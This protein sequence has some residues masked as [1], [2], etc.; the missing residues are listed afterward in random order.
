MLKCKI[1]GKEIDKRDNGR[2]RIAKYC[3]EECRKE[4]LRRYRI[5]WRKDKRENDKEYY[6]ERNRRQCEYA[7][8]RRKNLKEQAYWAVAEE[9]G[10]VETIDEIYEILK[11]KTRIKENYYLEFI[12]GNSSAV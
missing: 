5:E 12:N 10:N 6:T 4:G 9:V 11:K 8:A 2:G 3:S 7:R 1:C